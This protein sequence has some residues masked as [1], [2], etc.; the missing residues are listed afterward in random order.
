MIQAYIE[1]TP[2]CSVIVLDGLLDVC[3][4]YNDEIECREVVGWIKELTTVNTTWIPFEKPVWLIATLLVFLVLNT[5]MLKQSKLTKNNKASANT[6]SS[7]QSFATE[8]ELSNT[9]N[10]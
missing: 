3:L 1:N 4:N 8:F 7:L 10:Y 9:V 5:M 6:S 2:Q